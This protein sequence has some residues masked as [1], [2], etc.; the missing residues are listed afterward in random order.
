MPRAS[1]RPPVT[2]S[3]ELTARIMF[4]GRSS[5]LSAQIVSHVRDSLF[6]KQIKPGDFLG[7]EKDLAAQFGTSRI[8]GQDGDMFTVEGRIFTGERT[9][10]TGTGIFKTLGPRPERR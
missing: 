9:V 10:M 1:Q 8:V 5:S 3:G 7:T 2:M 6:A 4:A